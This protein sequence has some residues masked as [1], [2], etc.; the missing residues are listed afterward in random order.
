MKK[1]ANCCK[2]AMVWDFYNSLQNV[3]FLKSKPISKVG[4]TT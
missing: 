3:I 2:K 1:N 4:F